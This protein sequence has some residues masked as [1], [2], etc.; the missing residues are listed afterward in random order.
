VLR[1]V[2]DCYLGGKWLQR[3]TTPSG[4]YTWTVSGVLWNNI[5]E[6]CA[7]SSAT[8]IREKTYLNSENLF[9]SFND[10]VMWNRAQVGYGLGYDLDSDILK[11]GDKVYSANTCVLLPP[12]LN[13]FIQGRNKP[14]SQ[15]LPTGVCQVGNRLWVRCVMKDDVTNKNFNTVSKTLPLHD[16]ERSVE[17]Y[18]HGHVKAIDIWIERLAWSGRYSVDSRV[19][20]FLIDL[21][22]KVENSRSNV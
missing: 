20:D 8:Q 12:A 17:L 10:F 4:K 5:K 2:P 9:P 19:I 11:V 3:Y 22:H 1:T 16:V 13:R 18:R 6:R 21:K 14:R 7:K 15:A